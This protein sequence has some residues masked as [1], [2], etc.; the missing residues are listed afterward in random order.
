MI[1]PGRVAPLP[2]AH[3]VFGLS[4]V[5]SQIQQ[6]GQNASASYGSLLASTNSSLLM[7]LQVTCIIVVISFARGHHLCVDA[8]LSTFALTR[9]LPEHTRNSALRGLGAQQ[10]HQQR[11][12]E[13]SR[14]LSSLA[15]VPS[16]A[17]PC[18]CAC[19]RVVLQNCCTMHMHA[20][21]HPQTGGGRG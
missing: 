2:S 15:Q 1:I 10:E 11:E 3:G 4:D 6:P 17:T 7:Q 12:E 8:A 18:S 16:R 9:P 13:S 19:G 21:T 20:H 14:L 5:I